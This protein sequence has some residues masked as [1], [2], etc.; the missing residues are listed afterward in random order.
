MPALASCLYLGSPHPLQW[1]G[2]AATPP[3]TPDS[4]AGSAEPLWVSWP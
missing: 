4:Q 1:P 2:L 3:G